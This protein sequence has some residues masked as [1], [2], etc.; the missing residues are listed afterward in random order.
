MLHTKSHFALGQQFIRHT[1]GTLT[2][3][4]VREGPHKMILA[5]LTLVICLGTKDIR[6]ILLQGWKDSK[7]KPQNIQH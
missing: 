7:N 4:S 6:V 1:F 2:G 5:L 3:L